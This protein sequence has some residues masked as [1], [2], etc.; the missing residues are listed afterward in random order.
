MKDLPVLITFEISVRSW[1][2]IIMAL[3]DESVGLFGRWDNSELYP[4]DWWRHSVISSF[5][6]VS[7]EK[8]SFLC[9]LRL[10]PLLLQG[11]LP[12]SLIYRM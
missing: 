6:S 1:E 11:L 7:M 8:D 3:G 4:D 5:F 12:K 2:L 9:D 10:F